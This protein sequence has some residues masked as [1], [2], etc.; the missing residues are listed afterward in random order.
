MLKTLKWIYKL[1]QQNERRRI[2]ILIS[3]HH[4]SKPTEQDYKYNGKFDDRF[5]LDIQTGLMNILRL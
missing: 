3:D 1:G 5:S 2:K 4:K